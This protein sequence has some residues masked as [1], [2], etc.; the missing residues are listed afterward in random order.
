MFIVDMLCSAIEWACRAVTR[1]LHAIDL[2]EK[3]FE[4]ELTETL[5]EQTEALA[6]VAGGWDSQIED[7]IMM[8]AMQRVH[9]EVTL[10]WGRLE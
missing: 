10:I 5:N 2:A 7:T 3:A 8:D 6:V 9:E 4:R 1:V